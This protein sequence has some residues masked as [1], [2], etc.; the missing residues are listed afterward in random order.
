MRTKNI[1][2]WSPTKHWIGVMRAFTFAA[3]IG[4]L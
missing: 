3:R 1:D 4:A 2:L